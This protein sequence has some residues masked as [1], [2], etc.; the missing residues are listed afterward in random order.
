MCSSDLA[1]VTGG[2]FFAEEL[3]SGLEKVAVEQLG[4]AQRVVLTQDTT[5]IIG[6]AGDKQALQ[7]RCQELRRQ[8]G[9]VTSDFER[10]KLQERLAKL[11]GGVAVI[12][13]GAP[14]ETEM[15]NRKE[16]FEDAISAAKAAV[17]EGIVPGGGVALL[18]ASSAVEALEAEC[19]GDERTGLRVL[20]QALEK[21][22]RAHV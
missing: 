15:R 4:R 10:E 11:S 20:R 12:R 6:G 19:L 5:T 21:I 17:A 16:A 3:G 8:I 9:L 2:T 18:R 7:G 13:V 22:G 14:T 1:I